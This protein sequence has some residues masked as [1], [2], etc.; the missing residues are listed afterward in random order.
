VCYGLCLVL[1]EIA[2]HW[3]DLDGAV[4][5]QAVQTCK[6]V[7]MRPN[8]TEE[9]EECGNCERAIPLGIESVSYCSQ[10]G[11]PGEGPICQECLNQPDA[12]S[13]A[14]CGAIYWTG[15]QPPYT[16]ENEPMSVCLWCFRQTV[17]FS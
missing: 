1:D 6:L 17:Q 8:D 3:R 5:R 9:T 2:R 7:T 13:C 4:R 16:E 14:K 15:V 10:N 12:D 11:V